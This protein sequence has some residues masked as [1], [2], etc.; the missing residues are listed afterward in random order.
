[1]SELPVNINEA[2]SL[3]C[4]PNFK[5]FTI[6]ELY[7][8]LKK[9]EVDVS[10]YNYG[11]IEEKYLKTVFTI[12]N[13]SSFRIQKGQENLYFY[14]DLYSKSTT[15]TTSDYTLILSSKDD[16]PFLKKIISILIEKI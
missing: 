4:F 2:F 3:E 13:Y 5:H 10:I 9:N 14:I 12:S 6:E 15:D 8:F 1:M 16:I 11:S 7:V